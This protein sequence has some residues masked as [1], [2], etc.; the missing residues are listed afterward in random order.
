MPSSRL[1]LH[2]SA[3]PRGRFRKCH[4]SEQTLWG[5]LASLC[6][7]GQGVWV[8]VSVR[9]RMSICQAL[10]LQGEKGGREGPASWQHL[11]SH[12]LV[13]Y[14]G[15]Y[16]SNPLPHTQS[17]TLPLVQQRTTTATNSIWGAGTA[18]GRNCRVWS[19]GVLSA[20]TLKTSCDLPERAHEQHPS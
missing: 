10:L 1:P 11:F 15:L 4:L 7:G 12:C 16:H 9:W 6:P 19:L 14:I 18:E 3:T 17:L 2:H 20:Q 13:V 5:L 8:W